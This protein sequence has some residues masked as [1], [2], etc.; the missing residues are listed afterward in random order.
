MAQCRF[1][2]KGDGLFLS[3]MFS[4]ETLQVSEECFPVIP[5]MVLQCLKWVVHGSD[6]NYGGFCVR[7]RMHAN[8]RVGMQAGQ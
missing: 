3:A 1:S 8:A 4:G 6:L 7:K 5:G 2:L